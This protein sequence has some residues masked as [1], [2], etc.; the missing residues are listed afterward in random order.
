[1]CLGRHDLTE[2]HAKHVL[3]AW[4]L[5][6]EWEPQGPA[7]SDLGAW[8]HFR[9]MISP[10]CEENVNLFRDMSIQK[11]HNFSQMCRDKCDVIVK[12]ECPESQIASAQQRQ[13][14]KGP[15]KVRSSR[16]ASAHDHV[17]KEALR[18]VPMAKGKGVPS[19]LKC[20]LLVKA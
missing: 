4:A 1:M 20:S 15:G 9:G 19:G 12:G 6:T 16:S 13:C 18:K 17:A 3:R 14:E 7:G 11:S 2:V 8:L 5:W 10:E